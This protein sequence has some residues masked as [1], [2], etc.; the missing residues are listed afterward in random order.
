M[1]APEAMGAG[2]E[3]MEAGGRAW[4]PARGRWDLRS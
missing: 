1:R 2:M 4:L 3:A